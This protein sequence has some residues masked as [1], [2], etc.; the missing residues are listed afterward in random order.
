[1]TKFSTC[2]F[3]L[4][5]TEYRQLLNL[6]AASISQN[7]MHI[8]RS[9]SSRGSAVV[10]NTFP[11]LFLFFPGTFLYLFLFFP[12]LCLYSSGC[13]LVALLLLPYILITF[14][15]QNKITSSP[16]RLINF[17]KQICSLQYN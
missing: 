1:M 2:L 10:L 15:K 5:F 8:A 6:L 13:V 11:Y 4:S 12:S 7:I 17:L 3:S 16:I 9:H 14:E